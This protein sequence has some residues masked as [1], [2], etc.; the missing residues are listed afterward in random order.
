[1]TYQER[2]DKIVEL[3]E[4]AIE[5]ARLEERE[6]CAKLCDTAAFNNYFDEERHGIYLCA[7]LI[8]EQ[9]G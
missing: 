4:Q 1:M 2:L 6:R 8:R 7:K 5:L 3:Y 9:N